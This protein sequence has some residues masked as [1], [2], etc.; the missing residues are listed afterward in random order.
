MDFKKIF[1]KADCKKITFAEIKRIVK[2]VTEEYLKTFTDVTKEFKDSDKFDALAE[3]IAEYLTSP[4]ENFF[5]KYDS[6]KY[7]DIYTYTKDKKIAEKSI[8]E[9]MSYIKEELTE[10]DVKRLSGA[11][12]DRAS[13]E[14]V[15]EYVKVTSVSTALNDSAVAS[16]TVDKNEVDKEDSEIPEE[17]EFEES[18]EEEA[19]TF[20]NEA[21]Y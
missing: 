16:D 12:C 9:F 11:I 21:D 17:D 7:G 18:E 5:M 8:I 4:E 13:N 1:K 19:G 14:I 10:D 6:G 3:R 20:V 15:A 2:Q